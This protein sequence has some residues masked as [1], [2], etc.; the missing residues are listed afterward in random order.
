MPDESASD[1]RRPVEEQR[2]DLRAKTLIRGEGFQLLQT[3]A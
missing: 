1:I 2:A 3:L